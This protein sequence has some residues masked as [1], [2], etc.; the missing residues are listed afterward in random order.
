[1]Y[2][3]GYGIRVCCVQSTRKNTLLGL[4]SVGKLCVFSFLIFRPPQF[5]F[6]I[7]LAAC[8]CKQACLSVITVCVKSNCSWMTAKLNWWRMKVALMVSLSVADICMPIY[9]LT[10]CCQSIINLYVMELSGNVAEQAYTSGKIVILLCTGHDHSIRNIK[11]EQ[12]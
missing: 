12:N 2:L 10:A 3:L 1:M 8:C 4:F 9:L 6:Y 5:S 11:M 7:V